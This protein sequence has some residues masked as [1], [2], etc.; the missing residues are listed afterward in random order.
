MMIHWKIS[1]LERSQGFPIFRPTDLVLDRSWPSF[2]LDLDIIKVNILTNIHEDL[3]KN[4]ASRE[5]TRFF[6]F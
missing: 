1:P 4:M 5:V 2:D 3:M 6:Y